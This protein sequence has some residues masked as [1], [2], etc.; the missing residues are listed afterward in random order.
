M[1]NSSRRRKLATALT[2]VGVV[3]GSTLFVASPANAVSGCSFID[4]DQSNGYVSGTCY[5]DHQGAQARVTVNCN[6]VWPFTPWTNTKYVTINYG[7][8]FGY[9]IAS[10]P[11]PASYGISAT[12]I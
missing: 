2:V 10:C 3:L 5:G 12:V 4:Y 9:Y 8:S 11:W 6:A 7:L 1:I